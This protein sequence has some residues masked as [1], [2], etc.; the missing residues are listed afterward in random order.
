EGLSY[1]EIAREM[2]MTRPAVES[3]LFRAR[4]RLQQEYARAEAVA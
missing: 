3:A 2:D 4:R 1:R